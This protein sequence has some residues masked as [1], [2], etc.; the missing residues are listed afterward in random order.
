MNKRSAQIELEKAKEDLEQMHVEMDELEV[1]IA[2]QKRII[3]ALIELAEVAEDSRPPIG[4]VEGITS[5][6]KTAVLGAGSKTIYPSE[7][8]DRIKALGFPEQK[9]LL[10]SVHTVLKRLAEAGE[11][12]EVNGAYTRMSLKDR[13]DFI[14]KRERD[15]KRNLK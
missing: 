4:L 10:A 14:Q 6:C 13:V 11:I 8:R 7:V 15:Q 9:N 1:R 2:K 3:A 5:A 12:K